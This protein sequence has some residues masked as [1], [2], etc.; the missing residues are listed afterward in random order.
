MPLPWSWLQNLIK[1]RWDWV[2]VEVTTCCNAACLYCPR[3]VYRDRWVDRHLSLETFKK[4]L[5]AFSQTGLVHLQGWGEPLLNPDFFTMAALAKEAGCRVGTTTNGM[6]LDVPRMERLVELGV[7]VVAFSLAGLDE[8][9]DYF[10]PGTSLKKA[11]AA[12]ESLQKVK[13]RQGRAKPEIHL[14]YMLLGSGWPDLG[15]LAGL[16]E[17]SGVSQVVISTLDFVAAGELVEEAIRPREPAEYEEMEALLQTVAAD[18]EKR[19]LKFHYQL[20]YPGSRRRV[21]PEN[22]PRGLVVAADGGVSPCVYLNLPGGTTHYAGGREVWY[23]PLSFGNINAL[24]LEKI[25]NIKDFATFR[26]FF[27]KG[28]IPAACLHCLKI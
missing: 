8:K 12:L 2:Q 14:A 17:G 11:L 6:L 26:R 15:R 18:G 19:G 7:E 24:P 23:Q 4:L 16:L 22:P 20:P 3:T 27:E 25:W 28:K 13:E 9:N 5:P 1:P 21:C 10:R